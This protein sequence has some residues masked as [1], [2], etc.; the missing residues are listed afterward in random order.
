[1]DIGLRGPKW[2][3]ENTMCEIVERLTT[4]ARTEGINEGI[5]RGTFKTLYTLVEDGILTVS[6]AAKRAGVTEVVFEEKTQQFRV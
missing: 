5:N 6:D 4:E 1:V 2:N 3:G